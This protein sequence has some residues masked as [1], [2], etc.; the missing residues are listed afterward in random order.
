MSPTKYEWPLLKSP[1]GRIPSPTLSGCTQYTRGCDPSFTRAGYLGK[2]SCIRATAHEPPGMG[3]RVSTL[4]GEP[5]PGGGC[6]A[7]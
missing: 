7:R 6:R 2:R 1:T 4:D 3:W 5:A